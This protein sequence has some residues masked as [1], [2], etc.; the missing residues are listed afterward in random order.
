MENVLAAR[1]SKAADVTGLI[2]LPHYRGIRTK[3][4]G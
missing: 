2:V 1:M 3:A 4:I